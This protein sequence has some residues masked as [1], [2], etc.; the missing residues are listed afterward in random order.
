MHIRKG[1]NMATLTQEQLRAKVFSIAEVAPDEIDLKMIDECG[2]EDVGDSIA[3]EDYKAE[4]EERAF[5]GNISLRIPKDLHR[6]L[7]GIAKAQGVSLNQYCL[8]KLAK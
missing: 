4:R 7:V 1:D 5:N 2:N 6:D 3:W 8:Y